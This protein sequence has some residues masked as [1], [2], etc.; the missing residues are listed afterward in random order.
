MSRKRPRKE[1]E[2]S[3]SLDKGLEKKE[4]ERED[5]DAFGFLKNKKQA[6][7]YAGAFFIVGFLI[8]WF[9]NPPLTGQMIGNEVTLSAEDVGDETIAYI[10]DNLL[11]EGYAA[12][13]KGVEEDEGMFKVSVEVLQD[14]Q[15][16]GQAVEFFVSGSGQLLFFNEPIDMTEE[17]TLPE[18]TEEPVQETTIPKSDKPVAN[19]YVM[20]YCPYGLQMEKAV[21]PVMELLG[22]KADINIDY[23]PY[24]MHGEKELVQNNYQ[25]C[26]EKDQPEVFVEYLRC[27]VQSDDHEGCMTEAGVDQAN[28]D[29]CLADLEAEF[30]VT[31]VFESSTD[32]F[33]PYLVDAALASQYEV[34]GS[35]TFVLNGQT[36]SVNRSPEAIKAAIC[37]AFNSPPE[38]CSTALSTEAASAGIGPLSGGGSGST[39]SCG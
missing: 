8:S 28:L 5:Y 30:D 13:L 12:E 14:G 27:F 9:V 34:R 20:S 31:N 1:R 29:S 2:E 15:E 39:A 38:E 16:S 37:D 7:A 21:I 35:P 10:N 32:Q 26:I 33:P 3:E 18:T 4:Q 17:V 25:H 11:V 19:I 23:V 6:A 24:L 36:V 22:D